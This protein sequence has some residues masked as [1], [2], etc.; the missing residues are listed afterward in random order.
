MKFVTQENAL[1][2]LIYD[3]FKRDVIFEAIVIDTIKPT[4]QCSLEN[5]VS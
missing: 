2:P 1:S 5:F 4:E 3:K